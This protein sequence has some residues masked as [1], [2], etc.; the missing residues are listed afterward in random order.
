MFKNIYSTDSTESVFFF[1]HRFRNFPSR[2]SL[3]L[4][5]LLCWVLDSPIILLGS[6]LLSVET[7]ISICKNVK[8]VSGHFF[9]A[10]SAHGVWYRSGWFTIFSLRHSWVHMPPKRSKQSKRNTYRFDI[11]AHLIVHLKT[12]IHLRRRRIGHIHVCPILFTWTLPT[13]LS[14][15]TP[16]SLR[17][18]RAMQH[19]YGCKLLHS[20]TTNSHMSSI[21]RC[22]FGK[23]TG[24]GWKCRCWSVRHGKY[25]LCSHRMELK[26]CKGREWNET[27]CCWNVGVCCAAYMRT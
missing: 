7:S 15:L 6:V 21:A 19:E 9:L 14:M 13:T 23:H 12:I 22:R 5:L 18:Q 16:H 11:F 8:R 4:V 2:F 25:Y 24:F 10:N 27:C 1:S 3:W 20:F 17:L 26:A